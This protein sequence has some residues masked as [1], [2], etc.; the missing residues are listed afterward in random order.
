MINTKRDING[1]VYSAAALTNTRNGN[2]ITLHICHRSN[3]ESILR[4]AGFKWDEIYATERSTGSKRLSS[5]PKDVLAYHN[6]CAYTE[7][8]RKT[9]QKMGFR[10]LNAPEEGRV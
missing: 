2:T 8:W 5:L 4:K 1:N 9:L 3:M 6:E 7:Q 10:K